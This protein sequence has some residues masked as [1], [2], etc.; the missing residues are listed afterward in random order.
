MI[1]GQIHRYFLFIDDIFKISNR[2]QH[3]ILR[4]WILVY[5]IG[6]MRTILVY[7][8]TIFLLCYIH[9]IALLLLNLNYIN[10]YNLYILMAKVHPSVIAIGKNKGHAITKFKSNEKKTKVKPSSTKGRLGKRVKLI[11]QVIGE[12]TGVSTYEK[13]VI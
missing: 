10:I 12:V 8:S 4:N 13:R 5:K 1:I 9:F 2:S 3:L 11:R 7:Y 6:Q